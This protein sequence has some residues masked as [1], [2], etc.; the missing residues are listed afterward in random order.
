M[1]DYIPTS[2]TD[3]THYLIAGGLIFVAL[4]LYY[5]N[6]SKDLINQNEKLS[7]KIKKLSKNVKNDKNLKEN[8]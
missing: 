8:E 5:E 1:N 6:V 3:I 4:F 2:K 7:K